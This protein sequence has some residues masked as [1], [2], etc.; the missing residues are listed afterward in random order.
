ML[1]SEKGKGANFIFVIELEQL[2]KDKVGIKRSL[3]PAKNTYPKIKM[4]D[5]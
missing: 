4:H 2:Q 1:V 5:N 3:N